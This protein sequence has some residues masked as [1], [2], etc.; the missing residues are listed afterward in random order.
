MCYIILNYSFY[1]IFDF[2][3]NVREILVKIYN[4]KYILTI[5]IN[6]VYYVEFSCSTTDRLCIALLLSWANEYSNQNLN[7]FI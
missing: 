3:A 2:R 7:T 1:L 4:L 5:V 6:I